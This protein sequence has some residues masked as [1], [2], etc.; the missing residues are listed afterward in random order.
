MMNNPPASVGDKPGKF[1]KSK[2]TRRLERQLEIR[3]TSN[4][5]KSPSVGILCVRRVNKITDVQLA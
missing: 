5:N 1:P 4:G 2:E 3:Q